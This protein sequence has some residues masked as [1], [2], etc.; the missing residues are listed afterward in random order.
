MLHNME[1]VKNDSIK[2]EYKNFAN[3]FDITGN[4]KIIPELIVTPNK[5]KMLMEVFE[6]NFIL[7]DPL[8][9]LKKIQSKMKDLKLN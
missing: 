7:Q 1:K 9:L 5:F 6:D 4:K 3:F 2:I 8:N